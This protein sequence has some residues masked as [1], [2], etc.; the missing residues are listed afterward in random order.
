MEGDGGA[1]ADAAAV[2]GEAGGD[3]LRP[4]GQRRVRRD[5][6]ELEAEH[7]V[8]VLEVAVLGEH[9]PAAVAAALG[10]DHAVD[11]V[12]WDVDLGITAEVEVPDSGAEG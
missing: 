12:V 10:E 11:A 6:V 8:A 5:G 7:V 3:L 1:L 9:A 4:G 2:V